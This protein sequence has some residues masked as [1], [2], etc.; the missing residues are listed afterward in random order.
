MAS[1][2]PE[3]VILCTG[4]NRS[5]GFAI[6]QAAA[7]RLPSATYLL[8]SRSAQAGEEAIE[9]LKRLGVKAP[10]EVLELDVSK[11]S[12]IFAAVEAVK[13][14][15]G[16]LDGKYYHPFSPG[17]GPSNHITP[18]IFTYFQHSTHK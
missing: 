17:L 15:Y 11:D 8:G 2:H 3:Q 12:S 9:E 18:K 10:V 13:T 14:K 5:L 1:S 6:L 4:A 7:L 16:K